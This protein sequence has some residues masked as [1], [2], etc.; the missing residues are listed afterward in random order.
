MAYLPETHYCAICH[1][2]LG[3]EDGD[4]LCYSCAE[5]ICSDCG[6]YCP[7]MPDG[8]EECCSCREDERQECSRC[9]ECRAA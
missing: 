7:E 1:T 2:Y 6:R 3:P 5:R 9:A 4:G 8:V